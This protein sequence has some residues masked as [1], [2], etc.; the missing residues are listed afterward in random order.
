M[1]TNKLVAAMSQGGLS[2][3]MRYCLQLYWLLMTWWIMDDLSAF[4]NNG[5]TLI[6]SVAQ[7][8]KNE[9]RKKVVAEGIDGID[10]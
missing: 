3:E 9:I 7:F 6:R 4:C 2:G 8:C 5:N 10:R 1:T